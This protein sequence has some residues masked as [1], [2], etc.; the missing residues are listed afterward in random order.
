M[1]NKMMQRLIEKYVVGLMKSNPVKTI[2]SEITSGQ[3]SPE[4]SLEDLKELLI[5]IVILSL[6]NFR[7]IRP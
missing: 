7:D 3:Q 2:V 6:I 5:V 4:E 1:M